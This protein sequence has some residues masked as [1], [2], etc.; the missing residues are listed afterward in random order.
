MLLCDAPRD[1]ALTCLSISAKPLQRTTNAAVLNG[2]SALSASA[3]SN[4]ACRKHP[5]QAPQRDCRQ[6]HQWYCRILNRR[7]GLSNPTIEKSMVPRLRRSTSPTPSE[8]QPN[9]PSGHR[10]DVGTFCMNRCAASGLARQ[11]RNALDHRDI[12]PRSFLLLAP[13]SPSLCPSANPPHL[14][15]QFGQTFTSSSASAKPHP[16]TP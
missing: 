5:E 14:N 16:P 4:S 11:P 2:T 3:L 15:R 7:R 1:K 10:Y 6:W 8:T 9:R 13:D 12:H